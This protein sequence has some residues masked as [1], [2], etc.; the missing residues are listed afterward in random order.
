MRKKTIAGLLLAVLVST[1]VPFGSVNTYAVDQKNQTTQETEDSASNETGDLNNTGSDMTGQQDT[2]QPVNIAYQAAEM[3]NAIYPGD[4]FNLGFWISKDG[5]VEIEEG[6]AYAEITAPDGFSVSGNTNRVPLKDLKNSGTSSYNVLCEAS[7]DA[8]GKKGSFTVTIYFNY[9]ETI[10]GKKVKKA[11]SNTYTTQVSVQKVVA[12]KLQFA[13]IKQSVVPGSKENFQLTFDMGNVSEKYG[14][15]GGTIQVEPSTGL[16]AADSSDTIRIEAMAPGTISTQTLNLKT[17][18]GMTEKEYVTLTYTYTYTVGGTSME[19]T[20]TEKLNV[21]T[22]LTTPDND[23]V[24]YIV[25][26]EYTYGKNIKHGENVTLSVKFKNKSA[27]YDISNVVISAAPSDGLIAK[28]ASNKILADTLKKGKSIEKKLKFNVKDEVAT[29]YQSVTFTIRYQY[30][31]DGVATDVETT[32]VAN[33]YVNGNP[34]LDN[35]EE[36]NA[37][38]ATPYMM[39]ES[40]EYGGDKVAAGST[41]TLKMN[42]KNTSST[43]GMENI[44]VSLNASEDL[45]VAAASNTFYI[46]K[47]A[48]GEVVTK[49]IDLAAL[50]TAKSQSSII[51]LDSKYEFLANNSR[52]QV[53]SSEQISIPVYQQD[54]LELQLVENMEETFVGNEHSLSIQYANKGK[55]NVYN[56]SAE[57]KGNVEAA[58]KVQNLGNF[59]P[60][61]NGTI[62]FFPISNEAGEV[63]GEVVISYEDE[64]GEE[65]QVS[66][67]FTYAVSEMMMDD[68]MMEGGMFDDGMGGEYM[69]P[70]METGTASTFNPLFVLIPAAI[71]I[72]VIIV[73]L[74]LQSKKK[75]KRKEQMLLDELNRLDEEE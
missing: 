60:G 10:D 66:V 54:R 5:S 22:K 29:G 45:T 51:T 38:V 16:A 2:V 8:A 28:N 32:E 26:D 67:P 31:K 64:N 55:G 75:K 56:V 17:I 24:P 12:P 35:K 72:A 44:V 13:N 50:S 63:S 18:E 74:V 53:T 71:V 15:D 65:K 20:G 49:E 36:Q 9:F 47:L 59:E 46:E 30:M 27:D 19:V 25:L 11:G 3:Q 42:I 57:L 73:V 7:A 6:T 70:G 62:D 21:K 40:Y 39:V 4:V 34:E 52:Q 14:I 68:T 48:P 58:E 43:I 33:I 1:S 41:F 69:E 37:T 61:A 23:M